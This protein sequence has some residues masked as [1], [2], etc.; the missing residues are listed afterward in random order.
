MHL[1]KGLQGGGSK[2][3]ARGVARWRDKVYSCTALRSSA[4]EASEG[5]ELAVDFCISVSGGEERDG[6]WEVASAIATR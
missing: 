3:V 2:R 6:M 1:V 5:E 4:G